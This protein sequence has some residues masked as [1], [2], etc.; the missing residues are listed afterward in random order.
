MKPAQGDLLMSTDR[1][2]ALEQALIAV[3]AASEAAGANTNDLLNIAS[4]L[5]IGQ[6]PFR[7]VED[8]HVAMACLEISN[9]HATALTLKSE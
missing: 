6:S 7:K 1:E 4:G 2:V 3:I 9:A 8:R 5:I